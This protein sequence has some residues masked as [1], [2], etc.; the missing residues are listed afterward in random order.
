[1]STIKAVKIL[2]EKAGFSLAN[3][4]QTVRML[5]SMNEEG[6]RLD[7]ETFLAGPKGAVKLA[8]VYAALAEK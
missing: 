1:M 4:M 8:E 7:G 6:T 2:K 3:G 5:R